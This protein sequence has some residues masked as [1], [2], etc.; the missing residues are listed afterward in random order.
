MSKKKRLMVALGILVLLQSLI[1]ETLILTASGTASSPRVIENTGIIGGIIGYKVEAPHEV[2]VGEHFEITIEVYRQLPGSVYI[3]FITA[4]VY[5]SWT[6]EKVLV[7]NKSLTGEEPWHVTRIA[8]TNPPAPTYLGNRIL[9]DLYFSLYNPSLDY[10]ERDVL[11]FSLSLVTEKT[12]AAGE[13]YPLNTQILIYSLVGTTILFMAT[14][15]YFA[16]KK[17]KIAT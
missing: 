7:S 8:T 9:C 11:T 13:G 3:E 4:R 15:I 17:P 1:F 12:G 5:H 16:R 6:W 2:N 14:T 10:Y